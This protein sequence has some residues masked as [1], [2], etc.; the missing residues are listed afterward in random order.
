MEEVI[1]VSP[2][3]CLGVGF[4]ED[5]FRRAMEQNPHFIGQDAGTSDFGAAY[6]GSGNFFMPVSSYKFDLKITLDAARQHRIPLMVGSCFG[7]GS[8]TQLETAVETLRECAHEGGHS[9]KLAVIDAEIDKARIKQS[10]AEGKLQSIGPDGDLAP[11]DIDR[12]SHVVAQMGTEPFVRALEAG[13]DVV[14]AGRACDDVIFAAYPVMKGFDKGLALHM[15]KVLECAG[16]SAVPYDLG[17]PMIGRIRKDHFIV[18]PANPESHCTAVSVAAHSLYERTDPCIQPGPGGIN[19]LTNACFERDG[20]RAVK[21]SGSTFIPD[22]VYK[23]KLEGSE[24]IGYRSLC[25]FGIRD[26]VM[27]SQLDHVIA[28]VRRLTDQRFGTPEEAGYFA[29]I[30]IYGRD[31]VMRGLEPL[32]DV[33]PHEVGLLVDVVGKTQ[34]QANAI[35][36]Y[37]RGKI[38]HASYPGILTTA[39]NV[40]YPFSPFNVPVGPAFRFSIYH[41]MPVE[42]PCACFPMTLH[43]IRN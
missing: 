21:V 23:I 1:G 20:A 28:E 37:V 10:L 24:M 27:I 33:K 43:D 30:H 2:S 14:I 39:G 32:K 4:N 34:D 42:D 36:M 6:L 8:R 9:F 13:A 16:L 29:D 22:S 41:L 38:G 40:A 5:S 7:A 18:E 12:C 17:E 25:I 35:A 15:G 11:A 31:G 3:G 19:D 26:A